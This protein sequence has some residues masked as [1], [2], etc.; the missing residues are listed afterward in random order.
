M[1][2]SDILALEAELIDICIEAIS[3][4]WKIKPNKTVDYFLKECCPF[5]AVMVV[6]NLPKHLHHTD[7][8]K[9]CDLNGWQSTHIAIGF[10][11]PNGV[12]TID[13]DDLYY[14]LGKNLRERF[15]PI[16]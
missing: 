14:E 12:N 9:L 16:K 7:I 4:G 3:L 13:K 1:I 2:D 6:K 10:D 5:G 8:G 11:Y 15:C